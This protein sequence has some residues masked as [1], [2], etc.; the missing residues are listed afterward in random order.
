MLTR[1]KMLW[2]HA[3]DSLW[4]LPSVFTL[5]AAS[6]ALALV[7]FEK[8]NEALFRQMPAWLWDGGAEGARGVLS[9]IAGGLVTVTGVV[10][11][12]TIV[13]LQLASS[14][15]T[16]RLLRNFTAD[17][18]NQT[19]LAVFI[20]TFTYSLLVLRA[21]QSEGEG[22][23]V[24]VPR[25][26]STVAVALSLV[27]IGFLIYFIDHAS[28]SIQLSVILDRVTRQTI[29]HVELFLP[30]VVDGEREGAGTAEEWREP[31]GEPA[32][33]AASRSGYLQAV[34]E[35]GLARLAREREVWMRMEPQMGQ[36][37]LAG[38]PLLSVWPVEKVDADLEATV[39]MAFVLGHEP[40]PE[41][42]IEFGLVEIADIAIKALSPGINDPTTAIRCID[43]LGEILVAVGQRRRSP[44][45]RHPTDPVRLLARPLE[46]DRVVGLALDQIRHFGAANPTIS[47]K[48]V[49][50]LMQML[51]LV[52]ADRHPPIES[53][54]RAVVADARS[55]IESQ[56]EL[57]AFEQMVGRYRL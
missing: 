23:E 30:E 19:V 22:D 29:D 18:T 21:V 7:Q 31:P 28:K 12:V 45:D 35:G 13:A 32:V 39:R 10:F 25:L 56:V 43:R 47:R 55:S 54:L 4:F 15:F 5:T 11:S 36:F 52:P 16:P 27:S 44:P 57:S 41:Q 3:R 8:R 33:V 42:D 24:F 51:T 53:Q 48:L 26:A 46:Y 34:D 14:Q 20:G 1:L 40:T 6:A 49:D 2:V 50:L 17:R 38:R 9:T 37:I